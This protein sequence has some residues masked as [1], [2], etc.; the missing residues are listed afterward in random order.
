MMMLTTLLII[1]LFLGVCL[2]AYRKRHH[3]W[4]ER[5]R[6]HLY[7]NQDFKYMPVNSEPPRKGSTYCSSGSNLL[8]ASSPT[9]P[10]WMATKRM[11]QDE[12]A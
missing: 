5:A 6:A 9:R 7:A 10:D 4:V 12:L 11:I 1:S 2:W 3:A 8:D